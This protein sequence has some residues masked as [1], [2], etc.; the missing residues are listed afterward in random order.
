MTNDAKERILTAALEMFSQNGY[1]ETYGRMGCRACLGLW[2]RR[3]APWR[4]MRR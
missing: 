3:F 4:G 2:R 1:T